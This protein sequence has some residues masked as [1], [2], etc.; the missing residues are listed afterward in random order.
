MINGRPESAL[1]GSRRTS[2]KFSTCLPAFVRLVCTTRAPTW[3]LRSSN[4]KIRKIRSCE[5]YRRTS[6]RVIKSVVFTSRLLRMDS[7]AP[8]VV[9]D[10]VRRDARSR[11][12]G[13]CVRGA[14]YAALVCLWT[15]KTRHLFIR[16]A[17]EILCE[18][19]RSELV[20]LFEGTGR[21][22]DLRTGRLRKKAAP[23]CVDR[24]A[25]NDRRSYDKASECCRFSS[26][27]RQTSRIVLS[28]NA[29][30]AFSPT[31]LS[32]YQVYLGLT[33]RVEQYG[34]NDS[35]PPRRYRTPEHPASNIAPLTVL[36]CFFSPH[37]FAN[38]YFYSRMRS[39]AKLRIMMMMIFRPLSSRTIYPSLIN[40]GTTPHLDSRR[41]APCE[42]VK[43]SGSSNWSWSVPPQ[44]YRSAR[45]S[46]A[47]ER[48][49]TRSAR[50]GRQRRPRRMLTR[51]VL[52]FVTS[53]DTLR[54]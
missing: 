51:E 48:R 50:T 11:F 49:E 24:Q 25:K 12:T 41:S 7:R 53:R 3:C 29:A 33:G 8:S 17:A 21:P 5:I 32:L 27:Y 52:G 39:N 10:C 15:I 6:S 47:L 23:R 37:L 42:L 38:G 44:W 1:R 20:S 28:S 35:R 40:S 34:P 22:G 4:V 19:N 16:F 9:S 26:E 18:T 14:P 43:L 31:T 13:G 45:E 54:I 46:P 30:S 36:L 2:G